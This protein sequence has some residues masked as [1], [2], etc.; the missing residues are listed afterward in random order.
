[1]IHSSTCINKLLLTYET[2]FVIFLVGLENS[3]LPVGGGSSNATLKVTSEHLISK[4][5]YDH[6]EKH[7]NAFKECG[8]AT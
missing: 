8:Y 3:V 6:H 7:R 1:M 2:E 5:A 4:S